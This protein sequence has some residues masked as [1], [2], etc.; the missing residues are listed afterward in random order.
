MTPQELD[1]ALKDI[2]RTRNFMIFFGFIPMI[3]LFVMF[4]VVLMFPNNIDIVNIVSLTLLTLLIDSFIIIG[5]CKIN[6]YLTSK[7]KIKLVI[8]SIG[9]LGFVL[10]PLLISILEY[11][12]IIFVVGA[13][14]YGVIGFIAYT[15]IDLYQKTTHIVYYVLL[16]LVVLF[17]GN[18]TIIG[19]FS[20]ATLIYPML[21][22]YLTV[23]WANKE[24]FKLMNYEK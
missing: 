3:Y 2:R 9:L 12:I 13:I 24:F 1:V 19:I 8:Y 16:S 11:Y 21:S 15:N 22:S 23:R 4:G 7:A 5:I 6:N 20:I 14:Y 18:E 17:A 10:M